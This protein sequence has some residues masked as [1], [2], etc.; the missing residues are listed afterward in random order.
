MYWFN[1]NRYN[2]I[3]Y[4][5]CFSIFMK[6]FRIEDIEFRGYFMFYLK[7]DISFRNILV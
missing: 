3:L 2:K 6:F 1:F 7:C 4:K 5:I